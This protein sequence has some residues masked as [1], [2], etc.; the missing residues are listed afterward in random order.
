MFI[1]HPDHTLT[2]GA[3][4][5]SHAEG[6]EARAKLT[7]F[8]ARAKADRIY[9]EFLSVTDLKDKVGQTLAGLKEDMLK[10]R[11]P[12][13]PSRT[14]GSDTDPI[15]ATD[16]KPAT[17]G[18]AWQ[19]DPP[20]FLGDDLAR[21]YVIPQPAG[22]PPDRVKLTVTMVLP[23]VYLMIPEAPDLPR[24]AVTVR[25]A[26]VELVPHLENVQ[27]IPGTIAGTGGDI[28]L[29]NVSYAGTWKVENPKGLN[30]SPVYDETLCDLALLRKGPHGV[31]L[32]LR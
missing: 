5:E 1:M 3:V 11:R 32:T 8:I 30:T 24:V 14:A 29:A 25:P 31:K 28:P 18:L 9:A 19:P 17:G 10:R 23:S 6:P 4:D 20:W 22:G 21:L 12:K 15:Q 13:D 16:G 2:K 26:A 7:A 27:P